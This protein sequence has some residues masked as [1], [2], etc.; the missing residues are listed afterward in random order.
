[1]NL[2]LIQLTFLFVVWYAACFITYT[3]LHL[4]FSLLF[5]SAP[6]LGDQSMS[7]LLALLCSTVS[8]I[9]GDF[10]F[11]LGTGFVVS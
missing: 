8:H 1:M 5:I 4:T 10:L 7:G 6:R 11:L 9:P 2:N 3:V